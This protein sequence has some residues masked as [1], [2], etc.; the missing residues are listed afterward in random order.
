MDPLGETAREVPPGLRALAALLVVAGATALVADRL[1]TREGAAPQ[2]APAAGGASFVATLEDDAERQPVLPEQVAGLMAVE[3]TEGHDSADGRWHVLTDR[4]GLLLHDDVSTSPLHDWDAREP[5][6]EVERLDGDLHAVELAHLDER[7]EV[8]HLARQLLERHGEQVRVAGLLA[9]PPG[10]DEPVLVGH[11]VLVRFDPGLDEAARARLL[12]EAGLELLRRN[13]YVEGLVVAGTRSGSGLDALEAV[14]RLEGRPGVVYAEPNVVHAPEHQSP[15]AQVVTDG[16]PADPFLADQW[17]LHNVGQAGGTPDA[18]IDAPEA[19]LLERGAPQTIIAVVEQGF[20]PDH[21]DLTPNL[22]SDPQD[23][24]AH[25]WDFEADGALTTGTG[26]PRHRAHGTSV[27]GCAAARGDNGLGVS[28]SC[29]SCGLMLVRTAENS[30]PEH[31]G[32]S[33]HWARTHGADVIS[34]SWRYGGGM[35]VPDTMVEAIE[36]ALTEGRDG[37]GCVVVVATSNDHENVC[38]PG[39]FPAVDGVLSVSTSTNQ[40]ARPFAGGVG[41]CLGLLAPSRIRTGGSQGTAY[42]TTTDCPGAA[43]GYNAVAELAM[44]QDPGP[45]ACDEDPA[46]PDV[47]RCF[48]GT[49]AATPVTSGVAGLV[50]SAAPDLLGQEVV[51]LL[52]DTA[53]RVHD[54]RGL[55]AELDGRSTGTQF[56]GSGRVNA[57]EAVRVVAP[58]SQGGRGGVDLLVRDHRLDWGNTEQPSHVLLEPIERGLI[59]H[60]QSPDIRVDAPPFAESVP[61]GAGLSAFPSEAPVR[62]STNR[63]YVRVRNRGPL[64]SG[65]F[66]V[67][68]YRAPA[69]TA[70]PALPAG[71]ADEEAPATDSPWVHLGTRDVDGLAYSGTAVAGVPGDPAVVLP[72]DYPLP[73][74]EAEQTGGPRG[75]VLLVVVDG[76]GDPLAVSSVQGRVPDHMT[77]RDNNVAYRTV[78]PDDVSVTLPAALGVVV[79]NPFDQKAVFRLE[80][81]APDEVSVTLVPEA[82]VPAQ[83]GTDF[84]LLA[85]AEARVRVELDGSG[86]PDRA[87][88]IRQI[89]VTGGQAQL[90]GEARWPPGVDD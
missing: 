57:F 3:T 67:R 1:L 73:P 32:D 25:G 53:D 11:E 45:L 52:Q 29:P 26:S 77:P 48:G 82:P 46:H 30:T 21:P 9:H 59:G 74:A 90:L 56:N 36:L 40:D 14:S 19:W 12:D 54:S 28:G 24:T 49:S 76:A 68:L 65:P 64:S 13:A 60:G 84:S 50:L 79:A 81:E 15:A 78:L 80:V 35:A 71:F 37:K 89:L 4:V 8:T 63:V 39:T 7:D 38:G 75:D 27:A 86:T 22:W 83:P 43:E 55:Y 6:V 47:T 16:P 51:H 72:F 2:G 17:H 23:E 66:R 10:S 5:D 44:P 61:D 34:I 62:G 18:D 69:S 88:R 42:V 33:V 41:P 85:G 87:V 20:E 58:V 70:L 31:D